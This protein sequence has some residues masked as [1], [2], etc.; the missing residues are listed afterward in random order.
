VKYRGS[1]TKFDP[2]TFGVQSDRLKVTD[3]RVLVGL[4]LYLGTDT[5][6]GNDRN[7]TTLDIIDPL[8]I[9]SGPLMIGGT[10]TLRP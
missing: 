5:L 10:Q 9:A 4:R 1:E 3:Q 6:Q 7:G 8:S 2:I